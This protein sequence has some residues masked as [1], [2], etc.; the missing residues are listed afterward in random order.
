MTDSDGR[1]RTLLHDSELVCT[2]YRLRFEIAPYFAAQGVA[3]LYP[4]AEIAFTV[5]TPEQHYHLPLWVAANGY[6]TYRG[7]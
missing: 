2:E 5:R 6:T 7:S 1:C 4:F 3:S